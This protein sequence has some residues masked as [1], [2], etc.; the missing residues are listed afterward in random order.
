MIA[1]WRETV[2]IRIGIAEPCHHSRRRRALR[3]LAQGIRLHCAREA[4]SVSERQVSAARVAVTVETKLQLFAQRIAAGKLLQQRLS[5]N[6]RRARRNDAADF[7]VVAEHDIAGPIVA[8]AVDTPTSA[9]V[10]AA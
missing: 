8:G 4:L 3:R 6:R 7:P 2:R 5:A 10:T 9:G 1:P